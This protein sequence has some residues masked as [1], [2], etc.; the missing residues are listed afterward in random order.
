MEVVIGRSTYPGGRRPSNENLAY[1]GASE[2]A[3][4]GGGLRVLVLVVALA[5]CGSK[6]GDPAATGSGSAT[7]GSGSGSGSASPPAPTPPTPTP[8][9]TDVPTRLSGK[10]AADAEIDQSYAALLKQAGTRCPEKRVFASANDY[11]ATN[12]KHEL[13]IGIACGTPDGTWLVGVTNHAGPVSLLGSKLIEGAARVQ[14]DEL[15]ASAARVCVHYSVRRKIAGKTSGYV[16]CMPV[17]GGSPTAAADP[18]LTDTMTT[19]EF[20]PT[21]EPLT[22][23]AQSVLAN[24]SS[25]LCTVGDLA[26]ATSIVAMDGTTEVVGSACADPKERSFHVGLLVRGGG[27]LTTVAF[28]RAV[29]SDTVT[30]TKMSASD[31][32]LC[33]ELTENPSGSTDRLCLRRTR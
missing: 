18:E 10:V 30:F 8:V 13:L 22:S 28:T 6:G 4:G 2:W 3:R 29:D 5:A 19:L 21:T 25:K 31:N 16:Y 7:V 14:V 24:Q 17:S 23:E 33:L 9:V 32:L 11:D 15:Y 1:D 12:D 26:H 20:K 27:G